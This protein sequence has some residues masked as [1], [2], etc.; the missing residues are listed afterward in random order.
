MLLPIVSE[1]IRR[2]ERLNKNKGEGMKMNFRKKI[3][4]FVGSAL[5]VNSLFLGVATADQ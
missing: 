5:V 3:I 1:C 4:W 2:R